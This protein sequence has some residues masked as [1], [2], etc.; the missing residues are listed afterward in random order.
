MP[1]AMRTGWIGHR[2]EDRAYHAIRAAQ[3]PDRQIFVDFNPIQGVD[4]LRMGWNAVTGN[5]LQAQGFEEGWEFWTATQT[6]FPPAGPSPGPQDVGDCVGYSDCLSMVDGLAHEVY[7]L[8]E[9]ERAFLPLVWFSYGAGRVYVGN[10]QLG[11]RHGSTE[12]WQIAADV[13]YGFLPHNVSGL[14]VKPSERLEP[15]AGEYEA[16]S[17]SRPILDRWKDRAAPFRLGT[18][19]KIESMDDLVASV[20]RQHRPFTI[21]SMQG[22]QS[23]GFDRRYGIAL[24]KFGGTWAHQMYGRALVR[25]KENWF[26][27]VGNQ[28]GRNYHGDPGRGPRGGFWIPI[29]LMERW[30][31]RAAV[32]SRGR[33][34]GRMPERPDFGVI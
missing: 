23:A 5:H 34:A 24:W 17:W 11:R 12:A 25:I 14:T 1:L 9:V 28:W 4:P 29:E 22:F 30:L 6:L 10:N 31:P 26:F 3:S 16:W 13:E 15:P 32:Y 33:F 20:I 2:E 18:H 27:Y 19:S 7:W 21:A 8:D